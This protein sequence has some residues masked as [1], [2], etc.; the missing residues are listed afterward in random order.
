MLKAFISE[1][2]IEQS[3]LD[4]LEE[5]YLGYNILRLDPSP[6][7]KDVLPDGTGRSDKKE[8]VLPDVLWKSLKKL[9]PR[10]EEKY[11]REVFDTLRTDYIETDI[12]QKNYVLYKKIRDGIKITFVNKHGVDDFFFIKLVDFDNPNNNDFTAVSQMWI[13]GKIV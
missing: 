9:N 2:D 3:I 1:D 7:K 10:V 11:L 6:D 12:N 13:K 5:E 8:C 4:K